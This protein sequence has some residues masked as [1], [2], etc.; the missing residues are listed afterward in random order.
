MKKMYKKFGGQKQVLPD[1]KKLNLVQEQEIPLARVGFLQ[2][3]LL[4][5][6]SV[7]FVF[8]GGEG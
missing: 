6:Y 3:T 1:A 2:A 8:I 5:N 4:P 7:S